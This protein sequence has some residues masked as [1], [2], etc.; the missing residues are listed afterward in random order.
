MRLLLR[1]VL[2]PQYSRWSDDLWWT[3]IDPVN[4]RAFP[5]V[6][7]G[8]YLEIG[9]QIAIPGDLTDIMGRPL[10]FSTVQ[11]SLQQGRPM[12]RTPSSFVHDYNVETNLITALICHADGRRPASVCGR[13][14]IKTI[15]KR[16]K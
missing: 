7:I 14:V 10:S 6:L 13:P 1:Y 5:L 11:R 4:G 15:L 16:V 3:A 12:G 9:A 8:G 2:D